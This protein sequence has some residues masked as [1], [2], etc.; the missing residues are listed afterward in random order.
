MYDCV[1]V[2]CVIVFFEIYGF[3][4][5]VYKCLCYFLCKL[6]NYYF[7]IKEFGFC[8]VNYDE[9]DFEVN[10]IGLKGSLFVKLIR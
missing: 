4:F 6:Y 7:I 5:C 8:E 10:F 9:G 3:F 1:L 2:G